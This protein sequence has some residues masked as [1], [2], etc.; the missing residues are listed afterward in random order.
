M[1]TE[2]GAKKRAGV[3]LLTPE[4]AEAEL[5]HLGPEALGLGPERLGGDPARASRTGCTRCSAT[6]ARSPGSA[7]R[8]RTRSCTRAKLSPFAALDA[9]SDRRGDRPR[10]RTRSSRARAR[11]R[12]AR[13]RR[14]GRE[15]LP[16]AQQLGEPC[17]VCGDP[18]RARRLRGA[19]DLLLPAAARPA[20]GCS[21]TAGSRGCCDERARAAFEG[22]DRSVQTGVRAK[23]T[24]P[25]GGAASGASVPNRWP[26]AQ[27]SPA[28]QAAAMTE[29]A[30]GFEG[31]DRSVQTGVRAQPTRPDGGAASGASVPNR[32]P[33][34]EG[35]PALTLASVAP[36][37][38]IRPWSGPRGA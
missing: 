13:A 4:A 26:R 17:H 28:L 30:A 31:V 8:G 19:H 22:V 23:P 5:A 9:A 34:A 7:A 33:R 12:A 6:S 16:R 11:P 21:R 29:H 35:P 38:S 10:W 25:D 18:D 20:A 32:W 2:A 14:D 36:A 27:G 15:G 24:R 3:W 37:V 1:L